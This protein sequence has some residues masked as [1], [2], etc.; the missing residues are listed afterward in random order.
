MHIGVKHSQPRLTIA[1]FLS[2]IWK[3]RIKKESVHMRHN[4]DYEPHFTNLYW[5]E[6][7]QH[8]EK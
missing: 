4:P 7:S 2:H 1:Q 6:Y 3:E 5:Y 8:Y